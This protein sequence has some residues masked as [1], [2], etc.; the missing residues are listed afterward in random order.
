MIKG[1]Q[2]SCGYTSLTILFLILFLNGCS[3][4]S[5]HHATDFSKSQ[6]QTQIKCILLMPMD[7]ELSTL[8]TGGMLKPEA[9]WTANAKKHVE[10]ALRDRFEK[11]NIRLLSGKDVT[12]VALTRE[13]T[14]K[15]LQ[16]VKLHEAVGQSILIHQ[17]IP[18][19]KL[20]SKGKTFEWSLGPE[21]A[22]LKEKYG[23]DCAL[24]VY[25][26]DSYASAGRV[27]FMIAGAV[28]GVGVPLGQQVGFASLVE[29]DTGRIIWFNR[30]QNAA[31]DL[32]TESAAGN[33][34]NYLMS[35]F[36]I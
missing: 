11:K 31:G 21:A 4:T 13:E 32:R 7:I 33:S 15:Q 16:L 28:L 22:Y 25:L 30:L 36:P 9:E 3:T 1:V 18:E 27:A 19:L 29:L 35:D 26:R 12:D 34:V 24:F 20:P 17:Y 14:D 2:K 8:T 10:A 6:T 5:V 23:A